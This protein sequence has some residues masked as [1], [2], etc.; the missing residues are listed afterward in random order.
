MKTRRRLYT[1]DFKRKIVSEYLTTDISQRE[2]QS[3]Y[4]IQGRNNIQRWC[5]QFQSNTVCEENATLDVMKSKDQSK[6]LKKL[7][8]RIREL[9]NALEDAEMKAIAYKKLVENAEKE[10]GIRLPKKS[11][12]KRS[13]S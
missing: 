10:L 13:R 8:D 4:D 2:L 3:K 5:R 1:S 6:D 7:N 12:T 9:E 11:S